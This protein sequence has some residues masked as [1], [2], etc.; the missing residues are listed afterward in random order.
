M[1]PNVSKAELGLAGDDNLHLKVSSDGSNFKD[2]LIANSD[3]GSVSFPN[4]TDLVKMGSSVIDSGGADYHYGIPNVTTSFYG[5]QNLTMV[6]NR[7]YFCPVFVDRITN[8]VGGFVAQPGASS[9]A[10]ALMRAGIYKL[11]EASG[12]HWLLGERVADFGT[13]P[14]DVAGHKEFE[15]TVSSILD[16]VWY[17]FAL[18]TNG[19]GA[20]IR[21]VRTL[22]PCQSFLMKTGSSTSADLRFCGASSFL[23]AQSAASEIENG[24]SQNWPLSPVHD[25]QTVQPYGYLPFIPKWEKWS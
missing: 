18:G 22:Q 14:A 24:F 3:T 17:A 5:R 4:G 23:Y 21:N 13:H 6:R 12:H 16:V 25:L 15:P 10:G 8:I 1:C 19:A 11:G 2:S 20:V 7:V 9:T